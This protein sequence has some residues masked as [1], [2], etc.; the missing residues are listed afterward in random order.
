MPEV[1][2]L[3]DAGLIGGPTGEALDDSGIF[4]ETRDA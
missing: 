1:L 3:M 4:V 2:E